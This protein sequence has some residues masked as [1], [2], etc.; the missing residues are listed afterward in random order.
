MSTLLSSHDLVPCE[1]RSA[2]LA[3]GI[4]PGKDIFTLVEE[5]SLICPKQEAV[6]D[7][8]T[9]VSYEEL[10]RAS[11]GLAVRLAEAGV[12]P[13]EIVAIQLA[14]GWRAVAA[15]LAVAAIGAVALPYPLGRVRQETRA[16]LGRSRATAALITHTAGGVDYAAMLAG[17]RDELPDLRMVFV[18]DGYCEGCHRLGLLLEDEQPAGC[19]PLV[20]IDPDG[21]AR[22]LVSSGSEAEPKMVL[23]S[24]NALVG[25]RGAF[26]EGIRGGADPMRNM[27]LVPLGTAYGSSGTAVTLARHAGTLVLPGKFDAD[28]ALE[29]IDR[30]RPTHV[31]GVPAM[32]KMMLGAERLSEIDT[33]SLVALVSGGSAIDPETIRE[34]MA[35]FGCRFVNLY[36]SADGV[37]CYTDLDEPLGRLFTTAGRPDPKVTSMRIVD[38][39][40][41]NLP[42]GVAGEIHSR[43]PMSPMCYVNAPELDELYRTQDGWVRTGDLGLIDTDGY[44]HVVG[45]KKEIIIRGGH[46]ISLAEVEQLLSTHPSV[47]LAAC[48]GVSDETLGELLCACVVPR[49][50]FSEPT[51][52]EMNTF[53]LH[54]KGLEKFKL[55]E[56]LE[57]LPDIPTNPAGKVSKQA[58]RELV[59]SRKRC[60][61]DT[62]TAVPLRRPEPSKQGAR[63]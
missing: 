36:G 51:L 9:S 44:L 35:K 37:N 23:Y 5:H 50:G 18:S 13:G 48:L 27:F 53:L 7:E 47:L 34:C 39:N 38:D 29:A 33:S 15:D 6:V 11:R 62:E 59:L 4:Y 1:L 60:T 42:L 25:G 58:L 46:N 12:R 32:Y 10:V 63:P 31:F 52:E 49:P 55:P 3:G 16:L 17:L 21:P 28:R 40:G 41:Q 19:G 45:R 61:V 26:A 2:W 24:H 54:E 56:H 14:N 20:P 43:G 57:V 30:H 22:I 8:E